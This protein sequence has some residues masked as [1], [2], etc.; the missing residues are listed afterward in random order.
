MPCPRSRTARC[1]SS[2]CCTNGGRSKSTR[3]FG[4]HISARCVV[5]NVLRAGDVALA[6]STFA[7]RTSGGIRTRRGWVLEAHRLNLRS[8]ILSTVVTRQRVS[9]CFRKDLETTGVG[10]VTVSRIDDRSSGHVI[11]Y[12]TERGERVRCSPCRYTK[13]ASTSWCA[14]TSRQVCRRRRRFTPL[15]PSSTHS[16]SPSV[17]GCCRATSSSS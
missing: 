2:G 4:V 5:L 10:A 12:L 16:P 9:R 11:C 3:P 8:L 17:G 7:L 14:T 6:R 1:S 13:T 15:L